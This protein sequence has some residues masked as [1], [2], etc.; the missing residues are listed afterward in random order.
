M[1]LHATITLVSRDRNLLNELDEPLQ[2]SN[3]HA[4]LLPDL[5]SMQSV[6]TLSP[7]QLL[8]VDL[9]LTPS[10]TPQRLKQL[11]AASNHLLLIPPVFMH[12]PHSPLPARTSLLG[13]RCPRTLAEQIHTLIGFP[14][15]IFARQAFETDLL[16]LPQDDQPFAAHCYDLS[17]GGIFVESFRHINPGKR[18]TLRFHKKPFTS[19]GCVAWQRISSHRATPRYGAGIQFL[20]PDRLQLIRLMNQTRPEP[21]SSTT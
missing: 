9:E 20:F 16:V 17:F 12:H 3:I 18:V 7:N 19:E 15:R 1:A 8:V 6:Q 4:E 14:S 10:P 5:P 13:Q 11:A 2:R 21:C